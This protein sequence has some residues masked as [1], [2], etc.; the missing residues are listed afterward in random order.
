MANNTDIL[1]ITPPLLQP[2]TAYPATAYLKG[3][4]T[5]AGFRAGQMDLSIELLTEL[6]SSAFLTEVF[7]AYTGNDDPNIE[8]IHRL[9]KSYTG[10]I[11]AVMRFLRGEDPTVANLICSPDFLP[12]AGRFEAIEDLDAAYGAAGQIDCAKY[13]ATRYLEDVSDF[14]QAVVAPHFGLTRYAEKLALAVPDFSV[15]QAELDQP[16]NLIERKMLE[17]LD[18]GIRREDPRFVGFTVPFPGNL[19]AALRCA[20]YIKETYPAI[21]VVFGG[22][23]PTTELRALSDPAI[24]GY[25]DYII[26]DD[27]EL[28]LE[29]LLKGEDPARTLTLDKGKVVRSGDG[30]KLSHTDRGC[31]DFDGLPLEKYLS[32]ADTANP[33]QRLW[34]D[35]R[36]NKMTLAHGCYWARCAFCDTSL[37]YIRRY[38]ALDAVAA[39]DYMEQIIARTGQTGFHF[40]DEAAPPKLLKEMALE[41]LRRGMK[42]SWWG[43]IRFDPAFTADRC[44]LLAASGCVAVSGGVETASDRLLTLMNKGVTLEQLTIV[45]RNFYYAG[46]LT[47]AY[48]MYAFPTQTLAETVDALEVVR[49]L[50]QAELIGSAFWHRYAMTVHAPSGLDPEA[51]GVRVKK[52]PLRPFANNEI[53]FAEDRTYNAAAAGESLRLATA[54]YLRQAGLDKPAH[55][56]FEGKAP[57]T[58]HEPTLVADRLIQPDASR[59]YDDGARLVWIGHAPR[60]T[61][62]G[63]TLHGNAK[64]KEL[65]FSDSEADF[66]MELLPSAADLSKKLLFGEVKAI[67]ARHTDEPFLPFYHAKKWDILRDFGLLQ[68]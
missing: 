52:K 17:L 57:A 35:G 25:A 51:F 3:Y 60:R 62:E 56:W 4:L 27:G 42:V 22:G 64:E 55:K 14:L 2:N 37:D 45:L 26:L 32:L 20:Q 13:L 34:S 16:G 31:P 44:Q 46:I 67:F 43:N 11:D 12:Q 54:H 1:L 50:C 10:T 66:L 8:R 28:P 18:A 48:L 53:H 61:A 63:L 40:T 38:D 5:R 24:F 7:E 33:M 36:W 9:R 59:I 19:L 47:H 39:V 23:Y 6:F 58:T 29:Q 49:Q 30:E 21:K 68:L 65:K 41:I 15:L